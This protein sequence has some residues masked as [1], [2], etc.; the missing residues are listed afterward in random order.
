MLLIDYQKSGSF[1]C[2]TSF[3]CHQQLLFFFARSPLF[4]WRRGLLQQD[5][6][7]SMMVTWV[8]LV[9]ADSWYITFPAP[10]PKGAK[11][12]RQSFSYIHTRIY[13]WCQHYHH[14][15]LMLNF[16]ATKNIFTTT[17]FLT[18]WDT[19]YIYLHL[20]YFSQF[21]RWHGYLSACYA[22]TS[23]HINHQLLAKQLLVR[24]TLSQNAAEAV[25]C[26]THHLAWNGVSPDLFCRA[27]S[28]FW[29]QVY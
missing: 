12:C 15:S 27:P 13:A 23:L 2:F 19:P 11:E 4:C 16:Q 26:F 21:T 20:C 8:E 22:R 9:R 14:K 18:C 1:V 17:D 7:S 25:N 5:G 28:P 29:N 10:A 24:F 6:I 3:V